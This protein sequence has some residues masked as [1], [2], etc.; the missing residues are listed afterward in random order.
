MKKFNLEMIMIKLILV[1]AINWG[2]IGFFDFNIVEYINQKLFGQNRILAKIIYILVGISAIKL[3]K[4]D[5]FLPFLGKTVYPCLN[6]EEKIPDHSD[7]KISIKVQPNSNVVYWAAE[8]SNNNI[9]NPWDAYAKYANSGVAISD[10]NGN[11]ELKF[12]YPA[13]YSVPGKGLLPPHVHYRVCLGNGMMSRIETVN[14]K[15]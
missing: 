15:K 4:R 12:K 3:F 7:S 14:L 5:M 10:E 2:L 13:Q 9:D 11:V 8:K 6:L 1:G